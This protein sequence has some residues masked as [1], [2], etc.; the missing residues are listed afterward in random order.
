MNYKSLY[1]KPFT[2]YYGELGVKSLACWR[3]ENCLAAVPE[4][5]RDVVINFFKQFA[6]CQ[7]EPLD[8]QKHGFA[9][10]RFLSHTPPSTRILET[11]RDFMLNDFMLF[12]RLLTGPNN[13][14]H[15][16]AF[17]LI[18]KHPDF[19]EMAVGADDVIASTFSSVGYL[20]KDNKFVIVFFGL[21]PTN[22]N[23]Q[24]L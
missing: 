9:V 8:E 2:V 4:D 7:I 22:Q 15:T 24:S 1:D 16:T 12:C 14:L 21:K 6:L 3:S 18:T 19:T 10:A 23:S 17:Y 20:T 11:S 5:M 13:D